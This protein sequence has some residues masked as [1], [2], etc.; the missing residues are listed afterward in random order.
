MRQARKKNKRIYAA[1]SNWF[2]FATK[3]KETLPCKMLEATQVEQ[4]NE[5]REGSQEDGGDVGV[6]FQSL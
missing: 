3:K 4:E 5:W 6:E 2:V 1:D